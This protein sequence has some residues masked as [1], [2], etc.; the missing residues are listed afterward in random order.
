MRI[1]VLAVPGCPNAPVM[2][3]RIAVALGGRAVQVDMVEVSE[4]GEAARLGMT[5]S[6]TVL[7]DG[8]DPFA[9]TGAVPGVSCRLYR[10]EDGRAAGVPGVA[11]LRRALA[12]AEAAGREEGC[13]EPDLTGPAGRAGR[14]RRAPAGGGLRAVHQA[15][16]RHFAVIGHAPQ[17]G[18]LEEVA[19]AAGRTAGE[20]LAD[21]DREDFLHLDQADRIRAAYPFSATQ[22]RHR[23][24]LAS[25]VQVWSMCAIDALGMSSMLGQDLT[26]SSSDPVSGHLIEVTFSGGAVAWEPAEAAVFDGCRNGEGPA[27]VVCCDVLNFFAGRASAEQWMR[28]HPGVTGQVITQDQAVETG[29][30]IFGPLLAG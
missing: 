23:V 2:R 22:T 27:A 1:T 28:E 29:A 12:A 11:S 24:R 25:G 18:D 16:L 5:G 3:E 8:L 9:V 26:I 7:V 15:V 19:A 20:V 17:A 21:L 13:C 10:D 6:P 30:R 14:G 4:D